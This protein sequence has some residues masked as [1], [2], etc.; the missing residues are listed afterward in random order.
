MPDNRRGAPRGGTVTIKDLARELDLSITTISRGLNGYSDVGPETRKRVI[1]TAKRLGYRPNR[2]AQRLVT[3]R[4]HLLAWVQ[5]DHDRHFIDPHLA[6]VMGG[7]LRGARAGGYD[8]LLTGDRPEK[9][10]AVFDRYLRDNS[11]DGFILDLPQPGDKRISFL[12]ENSRPFVVHGRDGRQDRYGWVDVDNYGMFFNLTRLMLANGHQHIALINGDERFMFASERRRGAL[13]AFEDAG[14][15]P[16]HLSVLNAVHPMGDAGFQLTNAALADKKVT[17]IIYASA[18]MAVEGQ[19][20][21]ARAGRRPGGSIAVASMDDELHYLDLSPFLGQI[22]F[23][24]S[25]LSVAGDA[26]A[27]ELIRQCEGDREPRGTLIPHC[28]VL[29]DDIDGSVL[30]ISSEDTGTS[31]Q[32]G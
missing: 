10:I 23:V 3:K 7:V 21:L 32:T 24:R 2:N 14:V 27:K 26:L 9:L 29:G 28:F 11:V 18:Q 1:E 17:A 12:L 19:P 15:P 22:S 5:S 4:T 6:E 8:V 20:A 30:N 13:D 16:A 31:R 25:P